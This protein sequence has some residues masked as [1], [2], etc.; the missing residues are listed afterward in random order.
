MPAWRGVTP[1][2]G[3]L[4]VR[5]AEGELPLHAELLRV[6]MVPDQARDERAFLVTTLDAI[7]LETLQLFVVEQHADFRSSWFPQLSFRQE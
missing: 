7:A 1:S 3:T 4:E 5:L 2:T 6:Q